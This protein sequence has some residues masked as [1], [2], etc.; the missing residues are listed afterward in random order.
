[1]IFSYDRLQSVKNISL[2][3]REMVTFLIAFFA[4]AYPLVFAESIAVAETRDVKRSQF[5]IVGDPYEVMT[6]AKSCIIEDQLKV[7]ARIVSNESYEARPIFMSLID[8]FH[9]V[10]GQTVKKGQLIA[11]SVTT[12]LEKMRSIYSDYVALYRAQVRI[13]ENSRKVAETRR[14]R[15]E[16][17]AKKGVMSTAELE[18]SENT[19]VSAKQS[20]ER[21]LRGLQSMLENVKT[22]D[23]QIKQSN[24]YSAM[25]GVV[26]E[27][28][29]DPKSL[30]GN[31]MVMPGTMIAK[32]E[33][34]GRYRAE[35]QLFDN[36]VHGVRSGMAASVV[37][38]DGSKID[39]KVTYV[40]T[41]PVEPNTEQ[42]SYMSY[43]STEQQ[44]KGGLT[45]Y[46]AIV[47]FDRPGPIL[48]P[49]LLSEVNIVKSSYKA[50]ACLPWNAI[51]ISDGKPFVRIFE[52][53]KG[54]SQSPVVLGKQGRYHVELQTP[55]GAEA[56]VKSRLW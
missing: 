40:S 29:V 19:V 25:D 42:S 23:D 30:S 39:G 36:Q 27:L 47:E 50:K 3:C 51:E 46:K 8:K 53:G 43:G 33:K 26:T 16:D 13:A 5:I 32:I 21:M 10:K 24:F 55:L 56:L 28:I 48:P 15:I 41:L 44:N 4:S 20:E 11:T 18:Q 37:L 31:L 17:L 14:N 22:Y 2:L 52:D 34:P 45:F 7:A 6:R 12:S 38:P 1:M 9:V 35:A 54:W 49:S